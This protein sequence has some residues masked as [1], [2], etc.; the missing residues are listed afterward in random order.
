MI[1]HSF[2]GNYYK[3]GLDWGK[4]IKKFFIL[5]PASEETIKFAQECKEKIKNYT[6]GILEMLNGMK[7]ATGLD[8]NLL[9]AFV[10][11][12]GKE[13][14]EESTKMILNGLDLGCTSFAISKKFLKDESTIFARNYDW[15]ENIS[16]F[17][18]VI[19]MNP[20]DRIPSISFTD[21]IIGC[22][23]GIN[24]EGLA[25]SIH[26]LPGYALEWTPGIRMNV[27]TRWIL[28]NFKTVKDAVKFIEK[29]PHICGNIF[30][31]AD[32]DDNIV[33]IEIASE[34]IDVDY[35]DRGFTVITNHYQSTKMK[36]Y[37]F[38]NFIFE[39]GISRFNVINKWFNAKRE[40]ISI[41]EIKKVLSSHDENGVCNHFE[42]GGETTS[43][44][45]SWIATLNKRSVQI[46]DGS[47]C[48]EEY[49]SFSVIS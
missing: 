24:K 42:F 30:L 17:F 21:H 14:V 1:R 19:W 32:K 31:L 22:Y 36:K 49:K 12:L 48:K 41:E 20:I 33:K 40:N 46:C 13:M 43:T 8:S 5:P 3:I 6:P 27:L 45:W 26:G 39:N 34:E 7:D 10:L 44:I 47:P 4:I 18:T 28:D 29:V 35:A 38:K 37:E 2:T 25:M 23:G 9:D 15:L 11:A 16:Q